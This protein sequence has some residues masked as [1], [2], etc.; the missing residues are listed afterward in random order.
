MAESPSR[1]ARG[2]FSVLIAVYAILAVA[3]IGRSGY[4]ISTKFSEAPLAYSLSALAAV[5]YLVATV[6][7][8]ESHRR[9]G[10]VLAVS[11][12]LLEALGVIG[13]GTLSLLRPELFPADTV[14]S[15]FGQGYLFI[16]LVLPFVGLWWLFAR[17]PGRI[18]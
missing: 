7:L 4:Q 3:A 8:V 17:R 12:L 18:S 13:I 14:W 16:P 2:A 1:P 6:A 11:S 10:R 5:V 9:A 15:H